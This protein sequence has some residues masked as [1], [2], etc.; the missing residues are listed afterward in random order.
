M[1][2]I[3]IKNC[4]IFLIFLWIFPF[5]RQICGDFLKKCYCKCYKKIALQ[6]LVKNAVFW[7]IIYF[8]RDIQSL[9]LVDLFK[10]VQNNTVSSI[11]NKSEAL[12]EALQRSNDACIIHNGTPKICTSRTLLFF[13]PLTSFINTIM[14]PS[15]R[16]LHG[17]SEYC[18]YYSWKC[19]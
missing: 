17:D 2:L 16:S 4:I 18:Y 9:N 14:M 15:C 13:S 3:N 6:S 1:L 5:F 12:R 10:L 19:N 11:K 8:S 7:Y